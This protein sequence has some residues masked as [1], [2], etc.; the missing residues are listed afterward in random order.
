MARPAKSLAEHLRDG[1]FRAG[2][3]HGLLAG[4]LVSARKL[5]ALQVGY[6]GAS[7]ERERRSFAL[8]FQQ[9]AL[10]SETSS[11]VEVPVQAGELS[12][13]DFF[14]RDFRHTKGPHAGE[15]FVLEPWQRDF[16]D[17]FYRRDREGRRIYRLGLLGVPRG[18][19][20]APLRR[21][22]PSTSS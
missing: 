7:T 8:D 19:G 5:R 22:S 13:A 4:P 20:R 3:H 17:E 11:R 9:E 12:V 6:Q 2:R 16:V 21:G 1:S 18:N 15:S 14:A 10:R